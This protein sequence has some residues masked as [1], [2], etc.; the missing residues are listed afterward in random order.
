MNVKVIY[1]GKTEAIINHFKDLIDHELNDR[2]LIT[3]NHI[4]AV[5]VIQQYYGDVPIVLFF[6]QQSTSIDTERIHFL[7]KHFSRVYI[8]LVIKSPIEKEDKLQYIKSG[9]S[10]TAA[11][12]IRLEILKEFIQWISKYGILLSKTT[13]GTQQPDLSPFIMPWWKRTFDIIVSACTLIILFPLLL[14]IVAAIRLESKGPI[15]YK[16]KRVGSNYKVFYFLKF[17][18]MY[19]D[20]DRRL[21]EYEALN[22][23]Y[24]PQSQQEKQ[25]KSVIQP[26]SKKEVLLVSDNEIIQEK[27]YIAHKRVET[28]NAFKKFEHDPRITKVGHYLRKYSLDE[29]PQLINIFR[30][31]MSIVGNRPL[32]LYE[33][34]A[35]TTDEAAERFLAPAGLTGLWQVEKRG[36][37]GRLSA[38]ER[39]SLD[40]YYA[41]H[42]SFWLDIK[43]ILKTFRAF[44]QKEDV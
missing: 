33:A 9:V 15:I 4:T 10:N 29:L 39:K 32:P 21:K 13:Q 3:E 5:S 43:I 38:A 14:L 44:I 17:R 8:I 27:D 22:Q 7:H 24:P 31:D 36:D 2:L 28:E 1:I 35:L 25:N 26:V 41:K 30:G 40:V 19:Q 6:E 42:F 37:S 18:S 16:S 12:D 20:A 23:Y 11:S 34:E